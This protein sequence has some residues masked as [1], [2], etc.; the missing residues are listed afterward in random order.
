IQVIE[1]AGMLPH[2]GMTTAGCRKDSFYVRFRAQDIDDLAH[3]AF[4]MAIFRSHKLVGTF[5]RTSAT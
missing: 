3:Y 5:P 1:I 4:D 2:P